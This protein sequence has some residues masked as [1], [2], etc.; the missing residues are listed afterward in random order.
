VKGRTYLMNLAFFPDS[1][2]IRLS[3]RG[4]AGDLIPTVAREF[5]KL[6]AFAKQEF[7]IRPIMPPFLTESEVTFQGDA[8]CYRQACS[9]GKHSEKVVSTASDQSKPVS[10]IYV[11]R[12][13]AGVGHDVLHLA[14]CQRRAQP[15]RKRGL[16]EV[17]GVEHV[18]GVGHS[19]VEVGQ[20]PV[21]V[22]EVED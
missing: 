19:L 18:V 14:L 6:P 7:G 12:V 16:V 4:L 11:G 17:E 1:R 20:V 2:E 9:N 21:V 15:R 13:Q 22:Y 5:K 3:R 8:Y 10:S